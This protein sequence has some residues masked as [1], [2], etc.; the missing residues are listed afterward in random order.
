[1]VPTGKGT[2]TLQL[3]SMLQWD[4]SQHSIAVAMSTGNMAEMTELT[5]RI[6]QKTIEEASHM[7]II[8]WVTLFFLPGTF[9]SVSIFEQ[10]PD[11]SGIDHGTDS[12][13]HAHRPL[14]RSL[15]G[16]ERQSPGA[17]PCCRFTA[18]RGYT[19]RLVLFG[20]LA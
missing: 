13:E 15:G 10:R 16:G 14:S 8:T 3:Q 12:H 11:I 6:S 19:L 18:A 20:P 5:A 4:N 1:M 7:R 9:V 17:V 2:D